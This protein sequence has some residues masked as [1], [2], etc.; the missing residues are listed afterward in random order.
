MPSFIAW[1]WKSGAGLERNLVCVKIV[2][3]LGNVL[4]SVQIVLCDIL[5]I[6][7]GKFRSNTNVFDDL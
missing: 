3:L 7:F 2:A 1:S 4:A 6:R 5:G